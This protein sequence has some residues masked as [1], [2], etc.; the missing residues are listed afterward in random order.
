[1][2][3]KILL[4]ILCLMISCKES[5][6]SI[7]LSKDISNKE[8]SILKK[9]D[10][11]IENI[12]KNCE[13]AQERNI[14]DYNLCKEWKILDESQI[15]EIL[16]SG[17]LG[18][19]GEGDSRALHYTSSE[20]PIWITADMT[21]GKQKYKLKING[22][23]YFYL[24]NDKNITSLYFC[25]NNK[26]RTSFIS[27]IGT[28]DDEL[29]EKLKIKNWDKI[30]SQKTDLNLWQGNYNFDNGNFEQSYKSYHIKIE[31]NTCILYQ[32]DLP[33]CEIECIVDRHD[34]ELFL[35]IKS[36]KFKKSQYDVSYVESLSEGDYLLKIIKRNNKFYIQSPIIK[37]WNEKSKTFEKN[38]EI[39]SEKTN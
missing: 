4:P 29:Y 38:I 31:K 6:K 28:E 22:G 26:Y 18:D 12:S 37:Y 17:E 2:K 9:Q 35:Y 33:A 1:M 24:T 20:F 39:E 27:G 36:E 19:G 32:G 8:Y 11:I 30:N 5:K 10:T 13:E 3:K 15:K 23:S 34:N 7:S 16:K 21:V 14:Y 25:K